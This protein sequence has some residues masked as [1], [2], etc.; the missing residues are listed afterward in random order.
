MTK[1]EKIEL[2]SLKNELIRLMEVKLNISVKTN[3]IN[4]LKSFLSN[5]GIKLSVRINGLER[6]HVLISKSTGKVIIEQVQI[7]KRSEQAKIAKYKLLINL[8]SRNI[9]WKNM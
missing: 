2:I 7:T 1:E 3:H 5:N 6:K 9:T 4:S 8:L